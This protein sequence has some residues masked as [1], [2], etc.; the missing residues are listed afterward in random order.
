MLKPLLPCSHIYTTRGKPWYWMTQNKSEMARGLANE[1]AGYHC[2]AGGKR[3]QL[4]LNEREEDACEKTTHRE[5]RK[6]ER[7]D[8]RTN[9]RTNE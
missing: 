8:E 7:K 6:K 9:E 1:A 5:G 3:R 2:D 4:K